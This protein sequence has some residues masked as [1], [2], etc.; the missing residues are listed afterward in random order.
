MSLEEKIQE[1]E[2]KLALKDELLTKALTGIAQAILRSVIDTAIKN[3]QSVF[4]A[5]KALVLHFQYVAVAG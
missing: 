5:I 2:S 4:N 3:G 1:L